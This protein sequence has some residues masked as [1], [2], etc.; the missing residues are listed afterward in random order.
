MKTNMV[1]FYDLFLA[2]YNCKD[3]NEVH[4]IIC[5]D[6]DLFQSTNWK[7]LGG[8]LS[9][10]GIVK[11]QQSNPI[12]ALIEKATNS[13][14]AILTKR[15]FES[16]IDPSSKDAP[17]SMD[18]AIAKFFPDS[19]NWDLATHRRKQSEEIQIIA[20]GDGP[21]SSKPN[22]GTSVIVYDNG[23][24]QRP[25][26]FGRTFLSL[27]RGNKND[28][29]FVQGKY[30]MG[31]TGAIVFCGKKRYHLIAS[32][33]FDGG[34]FGFTLIREHP[35]TDN[36]HAKETWYEYFMVENKIP[37]FPITE[38]DL[39]LEGRKF[40]TGSI[41][42][43]YSYQFP[44][45][46]SAFS[47]DL[48]QS[49]NEYLYS[50][51]LPILTKD[52]PIRYPNNKVLVTDLYGLKRRLFK[53]EDEYLE[54][55]FSIELRNEDIFGEMK[56]TC[57]VFKTKVKEHDLKRTKEII[58]ER[59]F[60]NG[61]AVVFS[62][63]GQVHGHY[64][65]EFI[66]RS[67]K[68]NLLKNHLL[69]HV[70][71]TD[72][73]YDFRKELFMASR[74]RLKDGEETQQLRH[75]LANELSKADGRLAAIEK[76]RK[77]AAEIDTSADTQKLLR[78]F[79][80]NMPI[81]SELI[82]L[83]G[84]T[85]KLDIKKEDTKKEHNTAT[86][87]KDEHEPQQF[88][89][90]RFPTLF[91][92]K[93]KNDGETEISKIPTGSEKSIA[94]DTD[95]ENDYFDRIDEPGE[96]KLALISFRN[97]AVTGGDRAGTPKDLTDI[98]N[99]THSSPKDGT[100]KIYLNP[101]NEIYLGNSVQIKATLT[102]PGEEFDQLFWVKITDPEIPKAK[103]PK[104]EEKN[105]K[106]GLPPL[107]FAYKNIEDKTENAV[108]WEAVEEATGNEM[109][110]KTVMMPEAEGDNL[111][112]IF[113]NME[114]SVLMNFKSKYKN[115]NLEQL[116]VANRK[117][118]TSVYFHTLFLYTIT[119]NRGYE[120]HQKVEGNQIPELVD[121]GTYLKDVFDNYYSTFILNFG[122]INELMMGVGE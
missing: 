43:L 98:F 70:D 34:D 116:E 93:A 77:Q 41:L 73:K 16:K 67:L 118:Y 11:N 68:L 47:Q 24:G 37:S 122:G 10:Y 117:Y 88:N 25:E 15:C 62:L 52:I 82:K 50:P 121:L 27:V 49:I 48:N 90:K 28:I 114:S 103:T 44:K 119:K 89:P 112:K 36:D 97:N 96:L 86:K 104:P 18:E 9:N 115:P 29:H 80:K 2:L 69:I 53:E 91:R 58:H 30:N 54:D 12:A 110:Y 45:G 19:K 32:K 83:L 66:T 84:Q 71:C 1:N 65:S 81:D 87:T 109:D 38:L 113:V 106:I 102:A 56:V 23:E 108:S 5:A 22:A 64:T 57:F 31:G 94:F 76:R 78:D 59:Y 101:K 72:M 79:T 40:V 14:D 17:Q 20:D 42:K 7:P 51:A 105:D 99:I 6:T 95:I 100:I 60:K 39:G 3:E 13:I 26:D 63:N 55:K 4:T 85:F 107:V 75:L 8:N 21:R 33:R 74:D 92:L 111:T 120:I 61:M 35:K 46:Y